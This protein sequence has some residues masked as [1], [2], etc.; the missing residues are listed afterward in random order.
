MYH[1]LTLCKG[2]NLNHFNLAQ[3]FKFVIVPHI[4]KELYFYLLK[5]VQLIHVSC[6]NFASDRR[7]VISQLNF[8][9]GLFQILPETDIVNAVPEKCM[10]R[11]TAKNHLKNSKE[12]MSYASDAQGVFIMLLHF[13]V[14]SM[15]F[16]HDV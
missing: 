7:Y 15:Q 16:W 1:L 3:V 4:I 12:F 9:S 6:F 2:L 13:C 8:I 14:R 5:R 10:G 11:R